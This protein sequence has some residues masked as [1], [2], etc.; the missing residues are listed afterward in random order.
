V[1]RRSSSAKELPSSWNRKLRPSVR[2]R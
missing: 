1:L 2:C